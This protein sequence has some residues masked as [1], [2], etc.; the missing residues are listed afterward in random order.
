MRYQEVALQVH[1]F[2][3]LCMITFKISTSLLFM[4]RSRHKAWSAKYCF[5]KSIVWAK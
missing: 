3:W 4:G 5:G 1:P 2:D